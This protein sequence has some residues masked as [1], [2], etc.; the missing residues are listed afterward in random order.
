MAFYIRKNCDDDADTSKKQEAIRTQDSDAK[1]YM[2]FN[3]SP[4]PL[5]SPFRLPVIRSIKI[6]LQDIHSRCTTN[7][8][9]SLVHCEQTYTPSIQSLYVSIFFAAAKPHQLTDLVTKKKRRWTFFFPNTTH[10]PPKKK[11]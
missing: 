7:H 1:S 5:H 8:P 3:S 4:P 9:Y 11:L 6:T 2:F 10:S